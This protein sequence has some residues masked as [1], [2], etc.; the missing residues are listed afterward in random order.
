MVP[1]DAYPGMI[2]VE[3]VDGDMGEAEEIETD[4]APKI[5]AEMEEGVR[6]GKPL[7]PSTLKL[8]QKEIRELQKQAIQ[9]IQIL[10]E[11]RHI[12]LEQHGTIYSSNDPIRILLPPRYEDMSPLL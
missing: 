7:S 3:A 2:T 10:R 9:R 4:Y 1:G 12:Y 11:P 6:V 5:E 8:G